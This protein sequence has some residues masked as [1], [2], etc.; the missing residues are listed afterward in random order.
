MLISVNNYL[1]FIFLC[2]LTSLLC[3]HHRLNNRSKLLNEPKCSQR[4]TVGKSS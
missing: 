4:N 3:R 1:L 2:L